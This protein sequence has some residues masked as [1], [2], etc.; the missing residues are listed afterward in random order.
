MGL[1]KVW[2]IGLMFFAVSGIAAAEEGRQAIVTN[3]EGPVEVLMG[4][5]DW[6]PANEGMVL[7]VNDE[8]RSGKDG[9]A[10]ILLDE[11]GKTGQMDLNPESRL[12]FNTMTLNNQT[13]DKS[14]IGRASCRERVYVLV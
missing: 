8:I 11:G 4:G 3:T 2:A 1:K 13:G 12:R 5:K 9:K 14:K 10:K 6:K 7:N